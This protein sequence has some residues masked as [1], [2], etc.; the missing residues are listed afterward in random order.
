MPTGA[1][2][3]YV[4]YLLLD[5]SILDVSDVSGKNNTLIKHKK[6]MQR[7]RLSVIQ[8]KLYILGSECVERRE[9]YISLR[10]QLSVLNVRTLHYVL[11]RLPPN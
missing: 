9:C 10:D 11:N 5:G 3:S 2:K 1:V 6:Q 8:L 7:L 4:A